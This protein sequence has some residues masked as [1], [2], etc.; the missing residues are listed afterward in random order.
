MRWRVYPLGHLPTIK[1]VRSRVYPFEHLPAIKVM[2]TRVY[3]N[4][5]LPR[6]FM[7]KNMDLKVRKGK[8]SGPRQWR[9]KCLLTLNTY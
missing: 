1:V 5:Y 9:I 4:G 8:K 7:T 3:P 6:E 2:R